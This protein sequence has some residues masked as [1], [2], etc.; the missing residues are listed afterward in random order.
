MSTKRILIMNHHANVSAIMALA[1]MNCDSL[2]RPR[3]CYSVEHAP[4]PISPETRAKIDEETVVA[5][6]AKRARKR[7]AKL[8]R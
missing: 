8:N 7:L 4:D 5:A 1:A 6:E 3:G 2:L